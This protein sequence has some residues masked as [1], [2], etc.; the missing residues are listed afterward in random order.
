VVGRICPRCGWPILEGQAWDL[1][2][3]DM[4]FV[5]GGK[6]R[7][8]P[9]HAVCNRR[10][11]AQLGNLRKKARKRKR[12]AI[13]TVWPALGVEVAPSRERTW[14]ARAAHASG[15]VVVELLEPIPGTLTVVEAV[16]QAWAD[17]QVDAVGIDPSSPSATLVEPLQNA[18]MPIKPADARGMAVAHGKFR[19]LLDADRLRVR[20]HQALDDAVRVAQE[21]RLSG[22]FAVE[23]YAGQ[24]MS[25][26]VASELAVPFLTRAHF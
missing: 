1:D 7:L 18:S 15:R 24:D 3:V 20:G 2:H 19:D 11:G 13:I 12:M 14:M 4:P 16:E 22:A 17:W 25:P 6:G 9:A 21:R 10:A 26:L 8:V 23:R 5:D